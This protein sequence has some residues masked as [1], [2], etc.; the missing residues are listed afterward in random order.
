M[1]SSS[2]QKKFLILCL[3]I[4]TL[5]FFS[6]SYFVLVPV[7]GAQDGG[8]DAMPAR[9]NVSILGLPT[10][11]CRDDTSKMCMVSSV[12]SAPCQC[13]EKERAAKGDAF[14]DDYATKTCIEIPW[15]S[16]YINAVYR[17]GVVIG[18][19]IAVLSL[20]A[21]GLMYVLGGFNQT[22]LG[23]G[24]EMMVGAVTGLALLLGSYMILNL[25]NPNL[26]KLKPITV[27]VN[28][29][30]RITNV[31]FCYELKVEDYIFSPKLDDAKTTCGMPV[32][33]KNK[34]SNIKEEGTCTASKCPD[35][36]MW[37]MPSTRQDVDKLTCRKV[38]VWGYIKDSSD[39]YLDKIYVNT[40]QGHD[41]KPFWDDDTYG[42]GDKVYWI[43]K[44]K[45]IPSAISDIVLGIELNDTGEG[46][47]KMAYGDTIGGLLTKA[48]NFL[49][50]SGTVDD[51]YF[52]GRGDTQITSDKKEFATAVWTDPHCSNICLTIKPKGESGWMTESGKCKFFSAYDFED[53]NK[54][55]SK[56]FR[57]DIDSAMFQPDAG[58]DC[59]IW[60]GV[61]S[62]PTKKVGEQCG[63]SKECISGD[64]EEH[65]GSKR[66]EC[67][68]DTQCNAPEEG[69]GTGNVC[70]S[71][72]LVWNQCIKGKLPGEDCGDNDDESCYS[73]DCEGYDVLGKTVYKCE[74]KD[75]KDCNLGP[76]SKEK[77]YKEMG[78]AGKGVGCKETGSWKLCNFCTEPDGDGETNKPASS[79]K[80]SAAADCCPG[81]IY[82]D[83][84]CKCDDDGDCSAGEYCYKTWGYCYKQKEVLETCA[85]HSDSECKSD[86]C[87]ESKWYDAG[88]T[89]EWRCQC[90]K[91]ADCDTGKKCV[92][93]DSGCG[94]NYCI[95]KNKLVPAV[96]EKYGPDSSGYDAKNYPYKGLCWA[97]GDKQCAADSNCAT[98]W[99]ANNCNACKGVLAES[100]KEGT[101]CVDQ[102]N[103]IS[104]MCTDSFKEYLG[105]QKNICISAMEKN[106]VIKKCKKKTDCSGAGWDGQESDVGCSSGWCDCDEGQ[107]DMNGNDGCIDGY[108]CANNLSSFLN[109]NDMCVKADLY[110][111]YWD[112]K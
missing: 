33:F 83:G 38:Q 69:I 28:K 48:T 89:A 40:L 30:V 82:Q 31:K 50:T 93:V 74:C 67:N 18:S 21:G 91:D 75:N 25:I 14:C 10:E 19:V 68:N 29:E 72:L 63:D 7:V 35:D 110:D 86:S 95:A 79:N 99:G 106:G 96:P 12:Y 58:V 104:L 100:E 88:V 32:S 13:T 64:C 11:P 22:M 41:V 57:V 101:E 111:K 51:D 60:A 47:K 66:C 2:F 94:W 39:R 105:K 6:L 34:D 15:I 61:A 49:G 87:I 36:K 27:A 81:S 53:I 43:D 17:Y 62:A 45:G 102:C 78:K 84:S 108:I 56:G 90:Q 54:S 97:P 5:Q 9:I 107:G 3:F 44:V 52:V 70:V 77:E 8:F 109:G 16:Q 26:V 55:A 42:K 85:T 103:G 37:C 23:K 92:K 65:N 98:D 4:I 112:T 76:L 73:K 20:M 59:K 24:K 71:S 46:S 80:P 1:F